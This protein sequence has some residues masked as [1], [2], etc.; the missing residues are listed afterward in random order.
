[1]WADGRLA[2]GLG[3]R[4]GMGFKIGIC[5]NISSNLQKRRQAQRLCLGQ[6]YAY[7]SVPFL[8]GNIR[9]RAGKEKSSKWRNGRYVN[10]MGQ[11][12]GSGWKWDEQEPERRV[13]KWVE[14]CTSDKRW[15]EVCTN[16]KK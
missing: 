10:L 14:G 1:M 8:F 15:N 7:R 6:N 13:R 3:L 12:V 2:K 4:V 11:V 5:K 16:V 9:I